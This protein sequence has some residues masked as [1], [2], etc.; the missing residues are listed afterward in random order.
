MLLTVLKYVHWEQTREFTPKQVVK[1]NKLRAGR[2]PVNRNWLLNCIMR[3]TAMILAAWCV[4]ALF[5]VPAFVG[6]APVAL[7]IVVA[8]PLCLIGVPLLIISHSRGLAWRVV[9]CLS[10]VVSKVTLY[11]GKRKSGDKG[12]GEIEG[13]GNDPNHDD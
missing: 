7:A 10:T 12:G 13:K 4:A 2:R 8:T 5:V 6:F 3:G 1:D 9:E 11:M